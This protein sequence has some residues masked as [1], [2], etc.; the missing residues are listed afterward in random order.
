M[1]IKEY[2]EKSI[3]ECDKLKEKY[4]TNI[5][6]NY[7]DN[8]CNLLMF[9]GMAEAYNDILERINSGEFK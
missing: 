5:N 6:E 7:P 2:C 1:T 4:M 3:T 9:E 8:V